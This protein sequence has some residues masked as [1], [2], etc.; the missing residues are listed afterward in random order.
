MVYRWSVNYAELKVHEDTPAAPGA[1]EVVQRFLNLHDH[2]DGSTDDLAPTGEIVR[3][4]LIERD[5]LSPEDA[6]TDEDHAAALRVFDALHARVRGGGAAPPDSSPIDDA[7]ER[8]AFRVRFDERPLLEPTAPGADG[9]LG[10]LLSIVFLAELDGRWSHL[11]ECASETCH[12]VFY[13]RSKNDSAKW[14]SMR[15]CGN[16]HKVRAWRERHRADAVD[17]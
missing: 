5:L 4:Y 9:A 14:C 3:E 2:D 7:A 17:A 13:D 15:S 6:Y 11:K 1:L 8:A 12:S 10:R 16:Q